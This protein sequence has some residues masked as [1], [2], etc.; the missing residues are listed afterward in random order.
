VVSSLRPRPW[1]VRP[2]RPWLVLR[3]NH[4]RGWSGVCSAESRACGFGRTALGARFFV[5]VSCFAFAVGM[6]AGCASEADPEEDTGESSDELSG[7]PRYPG[8]GTPVNGPATKI[9]CGA[10]NNC[11]PGYT[12]VQPLCISTCGGCNP[13]GRN[14]HQCVRNTGGGVGGGALPPGP[15]R[16][17]VV[18]GWSCGA[19]YYEVQRLCISTCGG[20]NPYGSNAVQCAR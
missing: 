16:S 8:S 2:K 7:G 5:V 4:G 6:S 12:A 20:C 9:A 17:K 3:T 14:A 10:N 13:Y 18:C 15:P 11:G 1:L 19:G